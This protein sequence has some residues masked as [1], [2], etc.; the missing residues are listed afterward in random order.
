[1][2]NNSLPLLDNIISNIQTLTE[3]IVVKYSSKA[4]KYETVA[5]TKAFDYYYLTINKL[6]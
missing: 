6:D 5:Y 1:M 2:I 3:D 4:S